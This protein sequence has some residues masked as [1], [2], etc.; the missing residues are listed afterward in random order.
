MVFGELVIYSKL[1]GSSSLGLLNSR[2]QKLNGGSKVIFS[3]SS[4]NPIRFSPP[5]FRH[6][7]QNE[8]RI[9]KILRLPDQ[10]IILTHILKNGFEKISEARRKL[11]FDKKVTIVHLTSL[12]ISDVDTVCTWGDKFKL[13]RKIFSY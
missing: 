2:C 4:H 1:I 6:L 11:V 5:R 12:D 3:N 7:S 10:K 13:D 8:K 9:I